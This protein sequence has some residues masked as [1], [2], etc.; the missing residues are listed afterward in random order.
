MNKWIFITVALILVAATATN[1]V[2]YFQESS[3]LKDAQAKIADLEGNVSTIEGN[4]SSLE[5]GASAL[6]GSVTRSTFA[7]ETE[8]TVTIVSRIIVR[9][10]LLPF[11]V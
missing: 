8:A 1:G 11:P 10:I 3:K 9:F 7:C 4:V 5:A 6:E 2:L